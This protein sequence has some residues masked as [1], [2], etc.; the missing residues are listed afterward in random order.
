[1]QPTCSFCGQ[2][3]NKQNPVLPGNPV[4]VN[5]KT[6]VQPL[7]CMK[8]VAKAQQHWEAMQGGEEK[9]T[10][11]VKEIPTP[12]EIASYLD[13]YI[14]GQNEAKKTLAVA[15]FN[16]YQRLS[17]QDTREKDEVEIDKSNILLIGPTGCGKTLL[18][19]ALAKYLQVPFAI[20][21]A[22]SLTEAGYVGEDVENI[23]LRL[24]QNANGDIEAAQRGIVYV[25][26][27]D[28]IAKSHG[29]VS[30]TRDV[31]GEGVQ[32]ALLKMIEG[33]VSN[34]PPAGGRK[35]PEQQYI[36]IDTSQILFVCGGTFVGLKEIIEKR[37]GKNKSLG[38]GAINVADQDGTEYNSIIHKVTTEDLV[39]FGMIPEFIGRLPVIVALNQ[40]GEV[41]LVRVLNEPKNALVRQY[42]KLFEL[43]NGSKLKFTE[44]ALKKIVQL[45]ME[46]NT[47]A[48]AL[49]G[50]MEDLM[51]NIM[52]RLPQE[53]KA[54][55]VV[56]EDV[57]EGKRD[58]FAY[59]K[60]A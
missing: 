42:Q 18:A 46:R 43:A 50:V 35:H 44:A 26:E 52:F 21:D 59:N 54:T 55:Y 11:P 37:L 33:T 56:D 22:T 29:N 31:S 14:V 17:Y 1:M 15:V 53:P 23:L 36:P 5:T 24:I 13:Q 30:I 8:C 27:V 12:A 10:S 3:P 28:K 20:G 39:E 47:G 45:A 49:R 32:Q 38:F 57:V 16:H 7:I 9:A 34:V 6:E 48:R 40:L 4:K 41:E 2:R 25:D 60:A 58:I 51:R 19:K